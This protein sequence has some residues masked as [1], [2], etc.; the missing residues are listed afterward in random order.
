M[1]EMQ[2]DLAARRMLTYG[3]V[4]W[5]IALET[6]VLTSTVVGLAKCNAWQAIGEQA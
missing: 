4:D 5:L 1:L 2:C 3:G 6:A